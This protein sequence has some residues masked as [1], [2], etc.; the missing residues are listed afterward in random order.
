[1]ERELGLSAG[2]VLEPTFG[3]LAGV[4]AGLVVGVG[5]LWTGRKGS[6]DLEREIEPVCILYVGSLIDVQ[7]G[8]EIN[9][10]SFKHGRRLPL[11]NPTMFL[12]YF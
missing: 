2:L 4:V 11:E 1:M 8:F 10:V 6:L 9:P 5:S 3:G 7:A 12:T